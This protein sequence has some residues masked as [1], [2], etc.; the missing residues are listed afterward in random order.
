M[1]NK[2]RV[3]FVIGPVAP[4]PEYSGAWKGLEQEKIVLTNKGDTP[5]RLT[6][7]EIRCEGAEPVRLPPGILE[8]GERLVLTGGGPEDSGLLPGVKP[9]F[10]GN[11]EPLFFNPDQEFEFVPVEES[12]EYL[13]FDADLKAAGVEL[14]ARLDALE[15]HA[16]AVEAALKKEWEIG[17]E[18]WYQA[19]YRFEQSFEQLT[20]LRSRLAQT[21][22]ETGDLSP[23]LNQLLSEMDSAMTATPETGSHLIL[24]ELKKRPDIRE[25]VEPV[26]QQAFS[27]M[28]AI[29]ALPIGAAMAA[30]DS[31]VLA[32]PALLSG[33]ADAAAKAVQLIDW[34]HRHYMPLPC[35]TTTFQRISRAITLLGSLLDKIIRQ[36]AQADLAMDRAEDQEA[37]KLRIAQDARQKADAAQKALDD[38]KDQRENLED[39]YKEAAKAFHQESKLTDALRVE[40]SLMKVKATSRKLIQAQAAKTAAADKAANKKEKEARRSTTMRRRAERRARLISSRFEAFVNAIRALLANAEALLQKSSDCIDCCV[41]LDLLN[42]LKA[43]VQ[44][45]DKALAGLAQ[46]ALKA[47]QMTAD[48]KSD[49]K[50][51][52]KALDSVK[53]KEDKARKRKNQARNAIKNLLDIF[54]R[55]HPGGAFTGGPPAPGGLPAGF[56]AGVGP[57]GITSEGGTWVYLK[58]NSEIRDYLDFLDKWGDQLKAYNERAKKFADQEA[59]AVAERQKAERAFADARRK[60]KQAKRR[61]KRISRFRR[62]L[63]DLKQEIK[64]F[65]RRLEQAYRHCIRKVKRSKASTVY[66]LDHIEKL[67]LKEL[68]DCLQKLRRALARARKLLGASPKPEDVGKLVKELHGLLDSSWIAR[69]KSSREKLQRLI[70]AIEALIKRLEAARE[71]AQKDSQRL[72]KELR[73][74]DTCDTPRHVREM[75]EEAAGIRA[76]LDKLLEEC[77]RMCRHATRTMDDQDQQDSDYSKDLQTAKEEL[78]SHVKNNLPC[79]LL[80]EDDITPDPDNSRYGSKEL[81][82]IHYKVTTNPETGQHC[83]LYLLDWSFSDVP[84]IGDFC[85]NHAWDFE[86]IIVCKDKDWVARR[87]AWDCD[88]YEANV[89]PPDDADE[90]FDLDDHCL[91]V[92]HPYHSYELVPNHS[93]GTLL[94]DALGNENPSRDLDDLLKPLPEKLDG[95]PFPVDYKEVN[96]E[97]VRDTP[98]DLDSIEKALSGLCRKPIGWH[99]GTDNFGKP[100]I[101]IDLGPG[102]SLKDAFHRP[103][104]VFEKMSNFRDGRFFTDTGN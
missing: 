102:L 41:I 97:L 65:I 22:L 63:K 40:S 13:Q 83:I 36:A 14:E 58:G 104:K 12:I 103:W 37:K 17:E 55:Q 50:K 68:N 81:R 8:P 54:A 26:F 25:T 10:L 76:G 69:A 5:V 16:S 79:I 27:R 64:R 6:G 24:R 100:S 21:L 20:T 96:G 87:W 2:V 49:E 93:E 56:S 45:I 15:E 90:D 99:L 66:H 73:P 51:A 77:R 61:L 43:L 32:E 3:E 29:Q 70:A 19:T 84:V 4:E 98:I 60:Q 95:S 39:N 23:Q 75:E 47:K 82:A 44:K 18:A 92:K 46:E 89:A 57:M 52:K 101:V 94:K 11:S 85:F 38:L 91:R 88:H 86:P 53:E 35:E 7:A 31:L 48:G 62:R 80:T 59:K 28:V 42:A 30:T 74:N 1:K 67:Q 33:V 72:R 78:Y 34:A 71:K 9:K